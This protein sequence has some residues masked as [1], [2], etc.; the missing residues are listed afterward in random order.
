[1]GGGAEGAGELQGVVGWDCTA[2]AGGGGDL[3]GCH[4]KTP[5]APIILPSLV[6]GQTH[7]A[8]GAHVNPKS[9]LVH[10]SPG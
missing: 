5:K 4:D 1:M 7:L 2:T 8:A 9:S 3:D 6:N 10:I